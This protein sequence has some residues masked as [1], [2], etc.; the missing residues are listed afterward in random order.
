MVSVRI[1]IYGRMDEAKLS[2]LIADWRAGLVPVQVHSRGLAPVLMIEGEIT[3]FMVDRKELSRGVARALRQ[4]QL[5]TEGQD[6]V[7]NS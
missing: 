6:T 5:P 1:S 2:Q 7:G 4:L 3:D